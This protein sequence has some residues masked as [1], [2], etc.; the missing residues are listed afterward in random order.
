MDIVEHQRA[1]EENTF[2]LYEKQLAFN[3]NQAD[4]QDELIDR[5]QAVAERRFSFDKQS[6]RLEKEEERE[7]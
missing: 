2:A 7:G 5:T 1:I 4:V 3:Q 6:F